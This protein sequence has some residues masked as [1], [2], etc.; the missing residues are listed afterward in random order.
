MTKR[1]KRKG[2]SSR[3]SLGRLLPGFSPKPSR[4]T[5]IDNLLSARCSGCGSRVVVNG[6]NGHGCEARQQH[7]ELLRRGFSNIT[8]GDRG[9]RGPRGPT[10]K[11]QLRHAIKLLDRSSVAWA[12]DSRKKLGLWLPQW[13]WELMAPNCLQNHYGDVLARPLQQIQDNAIVRTLRRLRDDPLA[14]QLMLSHPDTAA[15]I[16]A[17]QVDA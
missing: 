7:L 15:S 13:A 5:P 10:A 8:S 3:V 2:G 6:R 12:W 1:A 17:A 14:Q 9:P 4:L 11:M 16:V